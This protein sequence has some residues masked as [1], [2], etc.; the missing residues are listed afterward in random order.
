[1]RVAR[2]SSLL[3]VFSLGLACSRK[4]EEPAPGPRPSATPAASA[5][6]SAK[7]PLTAEEK[8]EKGVKLHND[9]C[10]AAIKHANVVYGR[11]EMDP[12]GLDLLSL[13]VAHGNIAWHKCVLKATTPAAVKTC[14]ERLLLPE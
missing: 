14:E 1:V 6:A 11:P 8:R 7:A 5:A 9:L 12:K 10:N 3:L 13:C 4:V 2:P